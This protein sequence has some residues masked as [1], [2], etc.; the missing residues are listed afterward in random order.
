MLSIWETKEINVRSFC[1]CASEG[2]P[3]SKGRG[4]PLFPGTS[5]NRQVVKG[6]KSPNGKGRWSQGL[7]GSGCDDE[8]TKAEMKS[9]VKK[10]VDEFN[11]DCVL[12][13]LP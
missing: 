6:L 3:I 1:S 4:T 13:S 12:G 11:T 8:E 10:R 5:C 7:K 9:E 2:N